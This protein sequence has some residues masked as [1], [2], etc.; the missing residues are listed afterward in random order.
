MSLAT[1]SAET[2]QLSAAL[3]AVRARLALVAML[4]ALAAAG[5]W[6]AVHQ[7]RGMDNGPW[8]GL[9]TFVW[10]LGVWVVMM[11]AM[12]LPSV[13]PTIALYSRMVRARSA[14]SPLMFGAG[15]LAT[16]AVAG[17]AAFGIGRGISALWGSSLYW[18][19][20]GRPLAGA[21]LLAAAIYQVTPF[22]QACVGRCRSPLGSLLG[23]WRD[24]LVGAFRMGTRNGAW[25][26]GCCWALMVSLFALGVMNPVF[27]AIIAG[28]VTVEKTFPW[29]RAAVLATASVLTVLGI[30]VLLAPRA[31]PLLTLPQS[32]M[33]M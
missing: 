29:H 17:V 9:G 22:K 16:W 6:W 19:D 23:S 2:R 31:V 7:M 33:R 30:L 24:G 26:L 20:A 12:M 27:M 11:A 18:S 1:G 21:T 32:V 5:W 15:Y 8:T 3:G 13:A 28:L 14:A 25:C 10:F 4:L